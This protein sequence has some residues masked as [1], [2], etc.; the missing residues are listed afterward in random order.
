M[1]KTLAAF[2]VVAWVLS[3]PAL[4]QERRVL[5]PQD[6]SCRDW[7]NER[8][9]GRQGHALQFWVLGF[10]SS[11]NA[12]PRDPPGLDAAAVWY[13][14]DNYCRARPMDGLGQAA[15]AFMAGRRG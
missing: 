7:L 8:A 11:P 9:D 1:M 15:V 12:E 14:V 10:V 5:L 13:W 2:W 6:H 4:A 3:Q